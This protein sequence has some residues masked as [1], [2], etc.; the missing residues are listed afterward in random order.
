MPGISA[1]SPPSSAQPACRH[2][3]A[4]PDTMSAPCF[5]SSFAGREI[6]EKEHRLRA[7]DDEIVDAHGDEVDADRVMDPGL[8]G[9]FQ[10]GADAVIGRHQDRIA[11]KPA[12]FRSNNPPKPP[13]V[14]VRARNAGW[15]S[16]SA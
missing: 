4:M 1:V 15:I 8:D 12:A 6:V 10:L 16:P 14:A 7:L 2:P 5:T 3:S 11:E 13:I 9:D